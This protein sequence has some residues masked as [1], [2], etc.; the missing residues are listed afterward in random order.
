MQNDLL[1]QLSEF[2]TKQD[3]LCKLT[4]SQKLHQYSYSEIHTIHAI[5]TLASPNITEIANALKMTRSA[6]CKISKKLAKK[7]LIETYMLPDNKQKVFLKLTPQGEIL[8]FEHKKRHDLWIERDGKFLAQFTNTQLNDFVLFMTIYNQYL[9]QQI[10][11]LSA[12]KGS[13]RI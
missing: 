5:G 6:I 1:A 10:Q 9:E 2:L 11:M 8:F 3:I 13:E 12:S 4:E 7:G